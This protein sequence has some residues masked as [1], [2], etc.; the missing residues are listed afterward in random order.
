MGSWAQYN[1][2]RCNVVCSAW[3]PLAFLS[4]SWRPSSCVAVTSKTWYCKLL[5]LHFCQKVQIIICNNFD[6]LY[7][8]ACAKWNIFKLLANYI[9]SLSVTWFENDL[10]NQCCT[11]GRHAGRSWHLSSISS[12][13]DNFYEPFSKALNIQITLFSFSNA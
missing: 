1:T 13:K 2:Q 12:K 4:I 11:N 8:M 9:T 6:L 7:I 3:L 5:Q 10:R